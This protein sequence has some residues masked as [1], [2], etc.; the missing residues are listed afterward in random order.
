M[1]IKS[2]INFIH[3]HKM[4]LGLNYHRIGEETFETYASGDVFIR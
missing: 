3:N 4:K 1:K 2:I